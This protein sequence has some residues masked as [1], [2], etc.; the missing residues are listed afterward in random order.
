MVRSIEGWKRRRSITLWGLGGQNGPTDI[1]M[2]PWPLTA[3][4]ERIQPEEKDLWG[5]G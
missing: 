3:P 5:G 1:V 4:S 2:W